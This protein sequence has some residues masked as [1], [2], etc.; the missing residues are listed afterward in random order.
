[1]FIFG[2]NLFM[3]KKDAPLT[4]GDLI[5][6]SKQLKALHHCNATIDHPIECLN[7]LLR[8]A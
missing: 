8:Q 2:Q 4:R 5:I 7:P 3:I 1:M 6:F